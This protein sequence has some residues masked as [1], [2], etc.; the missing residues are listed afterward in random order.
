MV[1]I[2]PKTLTLKEFLRLPETKPASEYIDGKVIQKPMPPA[3]HS[4]I[5]KFSSA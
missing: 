1:Q 5:H 2:S 3:K 4:A